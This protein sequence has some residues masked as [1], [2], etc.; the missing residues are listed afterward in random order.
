[1]RGKNS[2]SLNVR[3]P[4]PWKKPMSLFFSMSR[5]M[6]VLCSTECEIRPESDMEKTGKGYIAFFHRPK[7]TEQAGQEV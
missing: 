2:I 7:Q 1:M 4:D 5:P 3:L 6:D